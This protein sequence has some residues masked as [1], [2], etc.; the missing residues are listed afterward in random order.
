MVTNKTA[1]YD[2]SDL[3]FNGE[4][5]NRP[6]PRQFSNKY[7][8]VVS[9]GIGVLSDR[10]DFTHMK[11]SYIW[12]GHHLSL[13][14][15]RNRFKKTKPDFASSFIQTYRFFLWHSHSLKYA[16]TAKLPIRYFLFIQR[17][18]NAFSGIYHLA[19]A[20]YAVF[21]EDKTSSSQDD[22][23]LLLKQLSSRCSIQ[24][25]KSL[26]KHRFFFA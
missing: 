22:I 26:I 15:K 6:A 2:F 25:T 12:Q 13:C 3:Q 5:E 14:L 1:A 9:T 17:D 10:P 11:Q 21:I 8:C 20:S 19:H 16:A 7:P 23:L 4:F 18:T 24:L